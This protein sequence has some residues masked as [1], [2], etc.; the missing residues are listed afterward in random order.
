MGRGEINVNPVHDE[1]FKAQDLADALVR[2][3]VQN[4]LDARRQKTAT[5]RFA[6]ATGAHALDAGRAQ[7]YIRGLGEHL[8]AQEIE[9]QSQ[10]PRI[11]EAMPFLVVEDFGTRGLTGDPFREADPGSEEKNHFDFFW[12][13]V[14]RNQKE[15]NDRGRWG[16]G[17]AV[18]TVA[19]RL[20]TFFG[21]T[22]PDGSLAPLLMGESVLKI[23]WLEHGPERRRFSPY[24]FFAAFDGDLPVPLTDPSLI[25]AFARDFRLMRKAAEPGLSIVI[26]W[27]KED[28]EDEL[29]YETILRAVIHQYF[30]PI[31]RGEL[32]V[33]VEDDT[34]FE[35]LD[36]K[37]LDSIAERLLT[38]PSIRKLC[39][40][41]RWAID[42]PEESLIRLAEPPEN[43]SPKWHDGVIPPEKLSDLAARFES[44]ERLAFRLPVWVQRVRARST[45]SF[46]D[47]FLER[48]DIKRG[49]PHFIRRGITIPDIDK[50]RAKPLRGLVVAWDEPIS[51]LLG[52]AENPAH[53]DWSERTDK[54]KARY[55]NGPTTVRYVKNSLLQLAT[56]LSRPAQGIDRT[57]LG[58]IFHVEVPRESAPAGATEIRDGA[59]EGETRGVQVPPARPSKPAMAV[60]ATQRGF[61]VRGTAGSEMVRIEAAYRV[62]SGNPFRK[63]SPLD[64]TIAPEWLR[65]SGAE[66]VS[67]EQNRVELRPTAS[68]YEVEVK[69]FDPRRDVVVRTEAIEEEEE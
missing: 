63:Y 2:E 61:V 42:L 60:T 44:G 49:E 7:G 55:K 41:T 18:F 67:A 14:G 69:G 3:A 38:E 58:D 29:R 27:P 13:N 43:Q 51:T 15:K 17:K 45:L 35:R 33:Y 56:I 28:K 37:S 39:A 53:S 5:V 57:L 21:L 11:G 22:V 66:L 12:R 31:M 68:E 19:S 30:Y 52:D 50:G 32:V 34:R 23:H 64:F 10:L 24:G 9:V 36:A 20:R 48:D 62:R 26:P 25:D 65:V 16:L 40:L 4:S 6:I 59:Q 54:I 46:V 47:I 8:E 1:F